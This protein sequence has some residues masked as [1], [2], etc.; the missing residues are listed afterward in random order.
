MK[1]LY[2]DNIRGFQ[3]CYIPITDVNFLLGENSSGK[4]TVL[5][6]INIIGSKDFWFNQ[7]FNTEH[8][9]L[10]NFKDIVSVNSED[11][12]SFKIGMIDLPKSKKENY[13]AC[14]T[15]FTE[16]DGL[17]EISAY[18]RIN[19]NKEL[20]IRWVEKDIRY[21]EVEHSN[22]D[23][24]EDKIFSIFKEWI[25][26]EK[27][28]DVGKKFSLPKE[29]LH[30]VMR[31]PAQIEFYFAS[32]GNEQKVDGEVLDSILAEFT[33]N[34]AWIA[35][36]RSKPK[37]IYTVYKT[38]YSPEGEH[39]PFLLKTILEQ[40]EVKNNFLKLIKKFGKNSGLFDDIKIKK[41]EKTP[42]APFSIQVKIGNRLLNLD[43][44]GY[45]VPQSLPLIIELFNRPKNSGF[46]IQQPEVHLHPKAQAAFGDL[47]F[48]LAEA[49]NKQF[50]IETHSDYTIDRF[51]LNYRKSK[52][53]PKIKSQVLFFEKD[54]NQNRVY[55]IEIM[56]NGE[57]ADNQPDSFQD[58]FIK[59]EMALLGL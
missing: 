43:K 49:E 1:I 9:R 30:F 39:T 3:D 44:V 21:K 11:K 18:N 50:L 17:L 54:N 10:G 2:L 8:I 48:D 37:N 40:K 42:A 29:A 27:G 24:N 13:F 57:Y 33:Y 38:S 55:P 6:L 4:T 36:I 59:E 14:L 32:K 52:K 53:K 12:S 41:Y 22:S 5:K 35:P 16:K 15:T 7:E 23:I 46:A 25:K 47:I 19:N 20:R 28:E 26:D 34:L 58:F 56:D 31:N 51:R 45:G